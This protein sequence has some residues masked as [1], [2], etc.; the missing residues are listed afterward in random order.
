M[1]SKTLFLR[2]QSPAEFTSRGSKAPDMP[3]VARIFREATLTRLSAP[4]ALG[5]VKT[6]CC[7]APG[8]EASSVE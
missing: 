5:F 7:G 8:D 1:A 4:V 2:D 6:L 3:G